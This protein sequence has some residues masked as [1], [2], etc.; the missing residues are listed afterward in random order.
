M[1][2][3]DY[4]DSS[5][6]EDE[7][8]SSDSDYYEIAEE[9]RDMAVDCGCS[10]S[11][12][13]LRAR[14]HLERTYFSK[15]LGEVLQ[16]LSCSCE[17]CGRPYRNRELYCALGHERTLSVYRA[18]FRSLAQ[19]DRKHPTLGTR[20]PSG[21]GGGASGSG[22]SAL[23]PD[24]STQAVI[25]YSWTSQV[26]C[27]RRLLEL[28]SGVHQLVEDPGCQSLTIEAS[29]VKKGES[30]KGS[31]ECYWAK[32]TGYGGGWSETQD[33]NLDAARKA[34][35]ARQQEVD[36]GLVE[37]LES[38]RSE[39]QQL[40]PQVPGTYPLGICCVLLGGTL[41]F[42]LKVL[43]SNDSLAHIIERKE[44]YSELMELLRIISSSPDLVPML[45]MSVDEEDAP[46]EE[47]Q[48]EPSGMHVADE[49]QADKGK[50]VANSGNTAA[51]ISPTRP[52]TRAP[53]LTLMDVLKRL[54]I[55]CQV[56]KQSAEE[57]MQGDDDE[58][59]E[60]ITMAFELSGVWEGLQ[61][62]VSQFHTN[63]MPHVYSE[64][65]HKDPLG[66]AG[67]PQGLKRKGETPEEEE[68]RIRSCTPGLSGDVLTMDEGSQGLAATCPSAPGPSSSYPSAGLKKGYED[69]LRPFLLTQQPLLSQGSHYFKDAA[70]KSK[71]ECEGGESMKRR[72]RRIT[73]EVSTL[74][75][76]L[77]VSWDSSIFLAMDTEHIDILRACIIP[78][79][80]TPYANGAFLF[81]IWLP[82][83]YP[84]RPPKVQF[85]T[86]GRGTVRFNPNLYNCGKVCLSL[87]GTWEGPSWAPGESTLL[88]V[89]ISLQSMVFVSEPYFNEPSLE[90][91]LGSPQ[92]T[93]A[94]R[95]YNEEI[96]SS[97]LRWAI[98]DAMR[99][100]DKCMRDVLRHHFS[101]KKREILEQARSWGNQ[102]QAVK[103][104]SDKLVQEYDKLLQSFGS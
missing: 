20:Q 5:E 55:Q 25:K 49:T 54:D 67:Q 42:S 33:Y 27:C 35:Q 30:K 2:S 103:Q 84:E 58:D 7:W 37:K 52:T 102:S 18:F 65:V 31:D 53:G 47:P 26:A 95:T 101:M 43:L 61:K 89:L 91:T 64:G 88:Q 77:P 15:P 94:S 29:E 85:L 34:V 98:H 38:I 83:E 3:E 28:T 80:D 39:L 72:L 69:T 14:I 21:L 48:P 92:G 57:L 87:L 70:L 90:T 10:H 11:A 51:L 22:Q 86:T 9:R 8:N 6:V 78:C 40:R 32:G 17:G 99:C 41:P 96:R 76:S 60:A 97:T 79:R 56:F 74:S 93:E 68:I 1:S 100:P 4:Q 71:K 63:V 62:A 16:E 73:H 82:L 13:D 75:T 45:L 44:V 46:Q 24:T 104:H 50:A 66:P 23:Q 81:D 59:M 12:E 36:K 19:S